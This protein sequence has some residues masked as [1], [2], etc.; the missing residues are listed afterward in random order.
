[1]GESLLLLES[2]KLD[3]SFSPREGLGGLFWGR[4]AGAAV[5]EKKEEEGEAGDKRTLF[6]SLEPIL[7]VL[8]VNHLRGGS[9]SL[10]GLGKSCC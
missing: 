1:M 3:F 7:R 5:A 10:S 9:Q 4:E 8:S 6:L 2:I